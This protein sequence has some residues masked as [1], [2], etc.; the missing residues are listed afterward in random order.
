MYK[1]LIHKF[2]LSNS[3]SLTII[4]IYIYNMINFTYDNSNNDTAQDTANLPLSLMKLSNK[5]IHTE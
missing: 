1:I 4:Y 5:E 2:R 3:L